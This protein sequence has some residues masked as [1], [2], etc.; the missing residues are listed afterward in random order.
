MRQDMQDLSHALQT[1]GFGNEDIVALRRHTAAVRKGASTARELRDMEHTI[2]FAS[3]AELYKKHPDKKGAWFQTE[4]KTL[5]DMK[6]VMRY[7]LYS[8][9]LNDPEYAKQKMYWWF[10]TILNAFEF[11][12]EFIE[13]AY[14]I[15]QTRTIKHMSKDEGEAVS[16]MIDEAITTFNFEP[17]AK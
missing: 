3:V 6:L 2:I 15:A 10:R 17:V 1:R 7:A 5:R 12:K 13:D 16:Q 9:I 4:V 14:R 8:I 11:G